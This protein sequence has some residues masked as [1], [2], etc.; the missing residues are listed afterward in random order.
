MLNKIKTMNPTTKSL[1]V[2]VTAT[3]AINATVLVVNLKA[4]KN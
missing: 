3:L 2:A 4:R 1:I